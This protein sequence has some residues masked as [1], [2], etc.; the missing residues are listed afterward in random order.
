[1]KVPNIEKWKKKYW[2]KGRNNEKRKRRFDARVKNGRYDTPKKF[3]SAQA[4]IRKGQ[5][6]SRATKAEVIFGDYLWR[7]G[8]YFTFQKAIFYPYYRIFDF[9]LPHKNIA[10]EVDGSSH[11]HKKGWDKLRDEETLKIR[12]I[13]VLR[14]TNEEVYSGEFE[15]KV[16]LLLGI[17]QPLDWIR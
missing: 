11:D 1:M 12:Y 5:L 6:R 17:N 8:I 7:R 9:Y 15:D 13:E 4:S 3:R 10:I 14:F 2:L 16:D